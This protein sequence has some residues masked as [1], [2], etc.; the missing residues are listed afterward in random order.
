MVHLD[1]GLLSFAC[2]VVYHREVTGKVF[3][4]AC[5]VILNMEFVQFHRKWQLLHHQAIACV[6]KHHVCALAF[7]DGDIAAKRH[8]A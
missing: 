7:G 1:G 2:F 3:R 4:H 5:V 8:A 6:Q